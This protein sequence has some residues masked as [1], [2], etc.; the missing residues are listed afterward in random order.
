MGQD[1]EY[2]SRHAAGRQRVQKLH[3][4]HLE[5]I[6]TVDHEEDNI[7]DLGRINHARERVGGA[8]E[9]RQAPSLRC[10]DG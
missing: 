7:R 9:E 1:T 8:F 2:I 5:A 4:L 10:H 6:I 3:C